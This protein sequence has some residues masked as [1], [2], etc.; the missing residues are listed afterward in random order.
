MH[1]GAVDL[2][3][4]FIDKSDLCAQ[5]LENGKEHVSVAYLGHIF[6]AA[7]SVYQKS[8]GDNGNSCVLCAADFDL[9]LEFFAA[10]YNIFFHDK[11]L[12]MT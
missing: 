11:H 8:S 6:N 1:V 4:G 3:G 12:P 7:N 2:N 9:T 5:I 10:V